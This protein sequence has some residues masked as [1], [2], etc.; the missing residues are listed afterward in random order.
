MFLNIPFEAPLGETQ[1]TDVAYITSNMYLAIF[2][3]FMLGFSDSCFNTQV[4]S[5]SS[6]TANTDIFYA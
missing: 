3:A 5:P 6:T 2:T 4:I 1:H